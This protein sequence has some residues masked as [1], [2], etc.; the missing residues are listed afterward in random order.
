MPNDV[1]G[2]SLIERKII[3][4]GIYD[5][6]SDGYALGVYGAEETSRSHMPDRQDN[7]NCHF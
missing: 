4:R 7:K 2:R 3:R 5:L 6:L 1:E